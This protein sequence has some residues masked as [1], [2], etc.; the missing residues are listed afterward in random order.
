V[1]GE[2]L[3]AW[4]FGGEWRQ[5][6]R[7]PT[8]YFSRDGRAARVTG[9]GDKAKARLLIGCSAGSRYRAISCA[10][11]SGRYTRV[12]LHRAV[13][14]LFNGPPPVDLPH[15]RHLD[16]EAT[17][18]DASNLAWGTPAENV[19]DSVRQGKIRKGEDNPMSKL[20]RAQVEEMRRIRQET[21]D[22]Y[23]VIGERF[24]VSRMTALR[25]IKGELWN[26]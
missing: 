3:L 14:E 13:C 12:Y 9:H 11:G 16:C 19:A 17:N 10:N 2:H 1:Q 5:Y 6:D 20:T 8:Y 23:Y 26:E 25:A 7:F 22:F 4:K 24:G 18:N 21:G 15:C